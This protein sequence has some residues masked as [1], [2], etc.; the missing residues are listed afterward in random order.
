MSYFSTE[1]FNIYITKFYCWL[2]EWTRFN[3]S[4]GLTDSIFM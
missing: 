4:L 1:R 2:R 3:P